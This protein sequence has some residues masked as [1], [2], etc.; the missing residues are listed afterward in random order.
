MENKNKINV[1]IADDHKMM[2]DGLRSL[3]SQEKDINIVG[4]AMNG[5]QVMDILAYHKVDIAVLDIGM[6]EM[7]GD[8]ATLS[9]RQKYPKTKILVLSLHKD[10][11]HVGKL[12]KSG[13]SGYIIKDRGSDELVKAIREIAAGNEYF[14]KEVTQISIKALQNKS[15][16][17]EK[18]IKFT[19]REIEVLHLIADGLSSKE[20][21][22]KLFIAES[23]VETNR[24]NLL[25]KLD[26]PNSKHLMKY[27]IENGFGK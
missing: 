25:A 2:L 16:G 7:N 27:A 8:E 15:L 12:L 23:T 1:L 4:E 11:R 10:E 9:I 6:P 14:D 24:K 18:T 21:G 22:K 17:N 26:L 3:L 13:V 20:I 5:I 19:P